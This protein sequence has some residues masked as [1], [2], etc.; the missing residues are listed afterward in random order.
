[1]LYIIGYEDKET[2]TIP[3]SEI[4]QV[5]PFLIRP[6]DRN[7]KLYKFSTIKDYMDVEPQ[8]L[9]RFEGKDIRIQ[10]DDITILCNHGS[11][12]Y[13]SSNQ[14]NRCMLNALF[15][16]SGAVPNRLIELCD[17]IHQN[18]LQN[19]IITFQQ[20]PL[21]IFGRLRYINEYVFQ[22]EHVQPFVNMKDKIKLSEADRKTL[23]TIAIMNDFRTDV[24]YLFNSEQTHLELVNLDT[25]TE[26]MEVE[27]DKEKEIEEEDSYEHEED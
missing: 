4:I 22:T 16:K 14:M 23:E 27:K 18:Y 2:H 25:A 10:D 12:D 7:Y 5:M 6:E 26:C 21:S 17:L 20:T 24:F 19:D 13:M 3:S 9:Q 1:M 15:G 8:L 11:T